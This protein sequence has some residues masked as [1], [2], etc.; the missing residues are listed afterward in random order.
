MCAR[1]FNRSQSNRQSCLLS[2][3][4]WMFR[5]LR[6][7]SRGETW[8]REPSPC[9]AGAERAMHSESRLFQ[10]A[11]EVAGHWFQACVS[12]QGTPPKTIPESE[13]GSGAESCR[14]WET[15]VVRTPDIQRPTADCW[16]KPSCRSTSGTQNRRATG[17]G[18]DILGRPRVLKT[19]GE[20][21]A[22]P[23]DIL[24]APWSQFARSFN[25]SQSNKQF[26]LFYRW[27]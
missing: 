10:V 19:V 6:S 2:V 8:H 5:R 25:R 4:R 9:E 21:R 1:S 20:T 15:S 12:P 23:W 3:R 24:A 13:C 14:P 16:A 17:T 7:I 26:D 27:L 22:C 11:A 18:P